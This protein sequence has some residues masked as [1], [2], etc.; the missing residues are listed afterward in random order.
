MR[1]NPDNQNTT[2]R[3]TLLIIILLSLIAGSCST[4]KNKLDQKNLIPKKELISI[5]ADVYIGDGLLS[6]PEIHSRFLYLDSLS[7]Y[8]QIIEKHG[9][10]KETM[11]KTMKY[12]FIREPRELIK[13]YDQVLG[14]LS[15]KES[16]IEKE[17]TLAAIH[18]ENLWKGKKLYLFPDP[19]STDST[20][21]DIVFNKAG[22]Y[23]LTFSVTL[24]P[25]DQSVNP[26]ITAY[27]CNPDS[28]ETGKRHYLKTINYAKDG[29]THIYTLTER[30]REYNSLHFRGRLYDFD[31]HPD[32]WGKHVRIGNIS[33]TY[34]SD[35]KL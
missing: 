23:T 24:F 29:H 7:V 28:I 2:I 14:V 25:D 13:I 30:T 34:S 8:Y 33:L 18:P 12:Y 19:W 21:F 17:E 5:L 11:D 16:L 15:M 32:E 3:F 1:K 35:A 22:I 10:T 26:R 6:L 9:Y 4:R 27:S 31:N 20:G